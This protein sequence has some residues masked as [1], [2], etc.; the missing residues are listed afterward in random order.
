MRG[1]GQK[2]DFEEV[3]VEELRTGDFIKL[4]RNQVVP[5]DC[6]ILDSDDKYISNYVAYFNCNTSDGTTVLSMKQ[7]LH[8][9]NDLIYVDQQTN[10]L[11]GNF[12]AISKKLSGRITYS[13]PDVPYEDF[14]AFIKLRNDP[15]IEDATIKNLVTRGCVLK[16]GL[17]IA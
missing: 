11:D 7:T 2:K 14:Q 13:K 1:S 15:K 8:E 3:E 16:S 6:L 12:Q 17:M 9:T 10:L 4:Y 5:C